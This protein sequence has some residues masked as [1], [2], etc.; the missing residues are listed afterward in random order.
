MGA[1]APASPSFEDEDEHEVVRL[2][3]MGERGEVQRYAKKL[4][5]ALGAAVVA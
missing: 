3:V 2:T 1:S 5:E 4:A